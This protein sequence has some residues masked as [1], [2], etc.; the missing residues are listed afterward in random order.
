MVTT[1]GSPA[2]ALPLLPSPGSGP[3]IIISGTLNWAEYYLSTTTALIILGIEEHLL[4]VMKMVK[5]EV[6][7]KL[8][9]IFNCFQLEVINEDEFMGVF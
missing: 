3:Q 9:H 8:S 4:L 1:G 2:P 5:D 7:I 6:L